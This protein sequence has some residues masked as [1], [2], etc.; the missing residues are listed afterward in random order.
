MSQSVLEH[1]VT[2]I[3]SDQLGVEPSACRP[4][5]RLVE[6]LGAD[7]LDRVE[8][9]IALEAEFDIMIPDDEGDGIRTVQDVIDAVTKRTATI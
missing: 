5:A 1:K 7:S 8:I 3:L 9:V 2:N 4:E 6:D